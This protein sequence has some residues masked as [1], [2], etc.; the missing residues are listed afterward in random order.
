[1]PLSGKSRGGRLEELPPVNQL[2][3]P[4]ED[5]LAA[6]ALELA[7]LVRVLFPPWPY[8]EE[9]EKLRFQESQYLVHL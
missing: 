3:I 7:N 8:Y 9:K 2:K 5:D 4:P 6:T 1:M